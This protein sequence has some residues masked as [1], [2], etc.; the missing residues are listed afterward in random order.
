[1]VLSVPFELRLLLAKNHRALSAVARIFVREVF[2]WQREQAALRGIPRAR[3]A[4]SVFRSASAEASTSMFVIMSPSPVGW[5]TPLVGPNAA[6][7]VAHV[8]LA[9]SCHDEPHPLARSFARNVSPL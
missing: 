2:H 6:M 1:V 9:G 3:G 5:W 7:R 4:P 8:M